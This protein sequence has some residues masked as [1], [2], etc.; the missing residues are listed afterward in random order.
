MKENPQLKNIISLMD[1]KSNF[2]KGIENVVVRTD[3]VEMENN[4]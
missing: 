4:Q 3:N 2:D 1:A